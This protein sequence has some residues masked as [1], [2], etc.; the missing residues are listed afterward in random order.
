M[1]A[2]CTLCRGVAT[3]ASAKGTLI[4][5]VFSLRRPELCMISLDERQEWPSVLF[6][7]GQESPASVLL[8]FF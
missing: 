8:K 5:Y 4:Y 2:S 1:I 7:V 6:L 3:T